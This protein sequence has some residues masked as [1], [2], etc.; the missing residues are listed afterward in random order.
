MRLS[1]DKNIIIYPCKIQQYI[2]WIT[3][4]SQGEFGGRQN[5]RH[6]TILSSHTFDQKASLF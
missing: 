1:R 6:T 5:V 3:P 4:I 2:M